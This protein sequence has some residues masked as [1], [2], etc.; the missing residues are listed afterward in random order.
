M[1]WSAPNRV[2]PTRRPSTPCAEND[3]VPND[4][5]SVSRWSFT[6][7]SDRS[8]RLRAGGHKRPGIP[9]T[10]ELEMD[11]PKQNS[12]SNSIRIPFR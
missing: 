7:D 6:T 1:S 2:H 10:E 8:K 4:D 5:G 9:A 11:D 12:L 3:G